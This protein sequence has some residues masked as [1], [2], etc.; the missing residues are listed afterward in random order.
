MPVTSSDFADPRLAR[1]ENRDIDG[2]PPLVPWNRLM[3]IG[4]QAIAAALCDGWPE[5]IKASVDYDLDAAGQ[6]TL[7]AYLFKDGKRLARM[8]TQVE[9]GYDEAAITLIRVE[10]QGRGLGRQLVGRMASLYAALGV[11]RLKLDAELEAGGYVWA[12]AGF[13]PKHDTAWRCLKKSVEPRWAA[14]KDSMPESSRIVVEAAL[15]S[16]DPKAVWLL[17]DQSAKTPD[18]QTLGR[19]LLA[20]T[21]WAGT[22][23]L[24]DAGQKARFDA[25]LAA[26][27]PAPAARPEPARPEST[28]KVTP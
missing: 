2:R 26:P 12:R 14:L 6:L 5:D 20:G 19:A 21:G 17:A 10:D 1:I 13:A 7:L 11:R 9:L 16:A 23:D 22:L 27:P 18:G 3:P 8:G 24:A 15:A 4:P 25:F 28:G